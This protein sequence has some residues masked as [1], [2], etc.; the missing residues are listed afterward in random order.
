MSYWS[1]PYMNG[2]SE[3]WHDIDA[4]IWS[5][6]YS[7]DCITKIYGKP[8]LYTDSFGHDLLIKTHKI[9]FRDVNV[10]MDNLPQEFHFF[11]WY[12]KYYAASL[13][14][15][16]FLHIDY[17][18]YLKEPVQENLSKADILFE[19]QYKV[20]DFDKIFDFAKLQNNDINSSVDQFDIFSKYIYLYGTGIFG[21]YNIQYYKFLL[22]KYNVLLMAEAKKLQEKS[23]STEQDKKRQK[24]LEYIINSQ[25]LA[26]NNLRPKYITDESKISSSTYSHVFLDKQDSIINSKI[27]YRYAQITQKPPY[28]NIQI[29]ANNHLVS[30]KVSLIVMPNLLGNQHETIIKSL[31]PKKIKMDRILV[32]RYK[33]SSQ[34]WS[35]MHGLQGLSLINEGDNY[36]DSLQKCVFSTT[37]DFILVLDENLNIEADCIFNAIAHLLQNDQAIYCASIKNS[38]NSEYLCGISKIDGE[39]KMPNVMQKLPKKLQKI[40]CVAGGF[41]ALSRTVLQKILETKSN[42]ENFADLTENIQIDKYCIPQSVAVYEK[43]PLLGV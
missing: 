36:F 3:K 40:D 18:V 37:S 23:D 15:T 10:C 26:E 13:Q 29:A 9:Q 4:R 33:L 6:F 43:I 31:I 32:S 27:K 16:P 2:Y 28:N 5:W 19:R 22:S 42:A 34:A 38:R 1:Q 30:S 39:Y 21:G 41:Y 11:Y 17:D 35:L 20:S 8:I 24:I 14:N 25:V 12:A 7:V